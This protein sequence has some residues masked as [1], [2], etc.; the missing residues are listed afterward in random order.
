MHAHPEC[1]T[2]HWRYCFDSSSAADLV[3]S[4]YFQD[5]NVKDNDLKLRESEEGDVWVEGLTEQQ[6]SWPLCKIC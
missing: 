2:L 3:S 6:V 4:V 1:G 5:V